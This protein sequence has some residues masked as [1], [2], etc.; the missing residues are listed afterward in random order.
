MSMKRANLTTEILKAMRRDGRTDYAFSRDTG[1][2]V[3][4]V[5][6]FRAGRGDITL[7]TAQKLCDE[8]GLQLRVTA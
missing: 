1:L 6:K 4:I 7:T 3:S 2:R 5:Q 8:L